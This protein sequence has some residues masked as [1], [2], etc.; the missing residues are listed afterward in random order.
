MKAAK[1]LFVLVA[2][3]AG[4]QA[5]HQAALSA[6]CSPPCVVWS[7]AVRIGSASSGQTTRNAYLGGLIID[8]TPNL[9]DTRFVSDPDSPQDEVIE[10]L[11]FGDRLLSARTFFYETEGV[12][13]D[14][15]EDHIELANSD[16]VFVLDLRIMTLPTCLETEWSPQL[17]RDD[18]STR[19]ASDPQSRTETANAGGEEDLRDELNG[20]RVDLDSS[21]IMMT[22]LRLL[23]KLDE[24]DDTDIERSTFVRQFTSQGAFDMSLRELIEKLAEAD[25]TDIER[26]NFDRQFTSQGAFDM[27]L[28][29]LIEKLAETDDTD[30]AVGVRPRELS[31]KL[32]E[33][34]HTET[35]SATFSEYSSASS[36]T[37]ILRDLIEQLNDI[38]QTDTAGST[39]VRQFTSQGAFDV[40]L[41]RLI[42]KLDEMDD[43]DIE[44]STF[45]RQFTSQGAFDMNLREL[46]EQLAETDDTDGAV[47][48][49]LRELSK[50]L[51]EL[52]HTETSSATVFAYSWAIPLEA[53]G[54]VMASSYDNYGIPI[55]TRTSI[56][57]SPLPAM[58]TNP[59]L[60]ST[61]PPDLGMVDLTTTCDE[62][63]PDLVGEILSVRDDCEGGEPLYE[64][65]I[66]GWDYSIHPPTPIY[67]DV[68]IGYT[69]FTCELMV[70]VQ[71]TNEGGASAAPC[72]LT[73][74][75]HSHGTEVAGSIPLLA[76]GDTATVH[77]E[78]EYEV[79]D[80][81]R[82]FINLEL[83]VDSADEIPEC[84][85][86]E[87]N[88]SHEEREFVRCR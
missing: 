64:Q 15:V 13:I 78:L 71:V 18:V 27:N 75:D 83:A 43:T 47:G 9:A 72:Q 20:I 16:T 82:G 55:I 12:V 59:A 19:P 5:L 85:D 79:E 4:A 44:R 46:I 30:G 86:G 52:D 17:F 8:Q 54:E 77:M 7:I 40:S 38:D 34:D 22:F 6:T 53:T 68:L 32:N 60:T 84:P 66:I 37:V 26:S 23:E 73:L 35:S 87:S 45:V 39:F 74:Y 2:L 10:E 50:Q 63:H 65:Q 24:M 67:G 61:L 41:Y 48:V 36:F 76:P 14:G 28:R 31:E 70:S 57:L 29:E 25:N 1:W 51:N 62:G 11:A 81:T 69:P 58:S 42:E 88:N 33:L 49:S 3:T 80:C 21:S 56:W